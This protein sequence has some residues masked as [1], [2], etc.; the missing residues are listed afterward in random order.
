M[1]REEN[2]TLNNTMSMKEEEMQKLK[3]NLMAIRDEKERLRRKVSGVSLLVC[4]KI[5][6][7]VL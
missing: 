5:E 7:V 4:V 6:S 2:E 3:S 1:L